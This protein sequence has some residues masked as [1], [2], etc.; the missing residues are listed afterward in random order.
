MG[1]TCGEPSS[2]ETRSALVWATKIVRIRGIEVALR[3][4]THLSLLVGG[5]AR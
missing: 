2:Y 5:I 3:H 4:W 1:Q